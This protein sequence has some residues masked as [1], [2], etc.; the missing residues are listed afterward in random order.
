M[1]SLVAHAA[2]WVLLSSHGLPAWLLD[3]RDGSLR[4]I[5]LGAEVDSDPQTLGLAPGGDEL[6]VLE[7]EA[8]RLL[9]FALP[10]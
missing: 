6:W 3:T 1:P 8:L 5:E 9:R 2:N 10:D 4:P 7:A